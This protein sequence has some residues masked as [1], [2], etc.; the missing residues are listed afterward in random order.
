[1]I[2]TL[3]AVAAM[4]WLLA[5][6][7]IYGRLRRA[8]IDGYASKRSWYP[9]GTD[10]PLYRDPVAEWQKRDR[11]VTVTEALVLGLVWPLTLAAVA[12]WLLITSG[13][14]L[15]RHELEAEKADA[16]RRIGEL[17]KQLGIAP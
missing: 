13:P 4:S 15:S 3:T 5:T 9:D 16:L 2:A 17:E 14:P 7:I 12:V 6:R 1:M 11:E 8:A 10:V